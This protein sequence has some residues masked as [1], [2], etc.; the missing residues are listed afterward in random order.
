[1]N[2]SGF[3]DVSSTG[4]TAGVYVQCIFLSVCFHIKA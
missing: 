2:D 1:M 4:K 3:Y